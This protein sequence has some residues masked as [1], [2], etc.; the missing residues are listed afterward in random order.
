MGTIV[1]LLRGSKHHGFPVVARGGGGGGGDQRVVGVILRDQLCT[2]LKRRRFELRRSPSPSPHLNMRERGGPAG[3][4]PPLT[5][6]A[7]MRPWFKDLDVDDLGLL[8]TDLS[9]YVNLRPYVNEAAQVT[10][11]TTS[12]R[13]VSRLFRLMGLR[14]LLVV[15]SC[16]KVVGIITRKDIIQGGDEAALR[17]RLITS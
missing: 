17:L 15:E 4:S 14:H 2:V 5:A 7:F 16:P 1:K 6:D 10:L 8:P 12:L 13:R 9:L 11:Q 3:S